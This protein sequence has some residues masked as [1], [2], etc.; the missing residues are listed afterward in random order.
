MNRFAL[1]EFKS[2]SIIYRFLDSSRFSRSKTSGLKKQRNAASVPSLVSNST[3]I[4]FFI[5]SFLISNDLHDPDSLYSSAVVT[6][7]W[8]S[9]TFILVFS[10]MFRSVMRKVW[11]SS[12]LTCR[13]L[14]RIISNI[15]LCLIGPG[16]L[17]FPDLSD[18]QHI[19][20]PLSWLTA[21]LCA[22]FQV[23]LSA[24]MSP[25]RLHSSNPNLCAELVDF[26][27]PASRLTDS[28][29][30]ASDYIK[31]QE[32]FCTIAQKG[33]QAALSV[34]NVLVVSFHM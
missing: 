16:S 31:L 6:E 10:C 26:Q 17:L 21:V 23:P 30:S 25:V 7:W 33:R 12:L 34:R 20:V 8:G 29:E 22:C 2:F 9:R 27:A 5:Y 28:A 3:S 15:W 14:D 19:T 32:E 11:H 24:S 13:Y 1:T 18:T 4:F